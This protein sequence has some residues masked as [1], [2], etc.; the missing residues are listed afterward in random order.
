[1]SNSVI[2]LDIIFAIMSGF[3]ISQAV[4]LSCS[5]VSTVLDDIVDFVS[6]SYPAFLDEDSTCEVSV[7]L[8]RS[9][10]AIR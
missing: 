6:P 2:L 5:Q 8:R 1:M 4:V 9:Y 10:S 7:K 3:A